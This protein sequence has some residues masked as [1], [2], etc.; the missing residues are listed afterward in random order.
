MKQL[1]SVLILIIGMY[2]NAQQKKCIYDIEEKTDSTFLKKTTDYL[3]YEKDF[4]NT[5]SFVLFALVNS[6]GTPFLNFQLMQKSKEFISSN[7]FDKASKISLQLTN[8]KIVT[9]ISTE[10]SC[11]H[12]IYDEKEK[13]NIRVLTNNFMFTKD[14]YED[15]KKYPVSIMKVR[16][17]TGSAEY[18]FKK[19]LKSESFNNEY[20]PENYFINYLNCVE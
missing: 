12:L 9:L 2:S 4:V 3:M 1:V 14:G 20:F 19:E 8:G 10:D 7:C 5:K 15:L 13:N 18:V 16:Y 6:D 11:G 17:S